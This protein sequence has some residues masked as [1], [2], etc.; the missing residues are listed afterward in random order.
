MSYK[1]Y[2]VLFI[3]SKKSQ[4]CLDSR[5]KIFMGCCIVVIVPLISQNAQLLFILRFRSHC[6]YVLMINGSSWSESLMR[7]LTASPF[8]PCIFY[9][10]KSMLGKW[11][12]CHGNNKFY[13]LKLR[14][15]TLVNP[16][17]YILEGYTLQSFCWMRRGRGRA[18]VISNR[19]ICSTNT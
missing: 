16:F 3:L 2:V 13:M 11:D 1:G 18:F 6:I 7:F 5:E 15:F 10:R 14:G 4:Q 8:K 9:K 17:H 19:A 12:F